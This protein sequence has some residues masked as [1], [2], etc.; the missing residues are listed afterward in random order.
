MLEIIVKSTRAVSSACIKASEIDE[1]VTFV[2][3]DPKKYYKT[4]EIEDEAGTR[5]LEHVIYLKKKLALRWK[6]VKNNEILLEKHH[7]RRRFLLKT[8][9]KKSKN[10]VPIL[11]FLNW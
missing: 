7:N 5:R 1:Y 9:L 11:Q 2:T 3:E 10:L 4:P 6:N 8:K